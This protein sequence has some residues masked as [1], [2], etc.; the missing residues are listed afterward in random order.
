[1]S[2]QG[3]AAPWHLLGAAA[4]GAL[5]GAALL[6]AA[7][8]GRAVGGDIEGS[9]REGIRG[10]VTEALHPEVVVR[11]GQAAA[12]G[13]I[14]GAVE[15]A[16]EQVAPRAESLQAESLPASTPRAP[17]PVASDLVREGARTAGEVA[18]IGLEAGFDVLDAVLGRPPVA[19]VEQEQEHAEDRERDEA[20]Q[21]E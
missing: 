4:A 21:P 11:T 16:L 20:S 1:M 7:A 15:G 19:E 6:F 12:R 13:L 18:E 10:G 8:P 3:R 17:R 9:V 5:L 2:G 14:T